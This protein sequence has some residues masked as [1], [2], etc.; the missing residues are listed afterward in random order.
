[1]LNAVYLRGVT[2]RGFDDISG[3]DGGTFPAALSLDDPNLS[4]MTDLWGINIV[5]IPFQAA[6]LL[7]GNSS[8]GAGEMLAGLD[9]VVGTVTTANA[10]VLLSMEA[11]PGAGPGTTADSDTFRAWS[12]LANHYQDEPGVL[13]ELF[14]SPQPLAD[15]WLDIAAMLVGTIRLQNPAALIFL[16]S[17]KG[18]A[19]IS[20]LPLR[21]ST[22]DPV[23]N[24]VYTIEASDT[25]APD[26]D[27]AQLRAFAAAYPLFASPWSDASANSDRSSEGTANLFGRYGMGW[28]A[29]NWNADPRLVRSSID[30]DFTPTRW[31]FVAQRAFAQPVKPMLPPVRLE[32]EA[33]SAWRLA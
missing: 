16:S 18:G 15:G 20:G 9:E 21:F 19:D 4:T 6:T 30:H 2:C 29:A 11:Q 14:S 23:F 31:G 32:D 8:F 12:L 13:Y 3:S 28:I 25:L 10:R 22:G 26:P 5:R 24:I 17:G 7:S 27:D 33:A 1:L